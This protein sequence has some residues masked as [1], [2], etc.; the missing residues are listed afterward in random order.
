MKDRAPT[1]YVTGAYLRYLEDPK[2]DLQLSPDERGVR[3]E[4][5]VPVKFS[6]PE[7]C[8]VQDPLGALASPEEPGLQHLGW[9]NR[10]ARAV[11]TPICYVTRHEDVRLDRLG[12]P[13]W[14]H[15]FRRYGDPAILRDA[16]NAPIEVY[17]TE[18]GRAITAFE[19]FGWEDHLQLMAASDVFRP[20]LEKVRDFFETLHT[21]DATL[22]PILQTFPGG[23][24]WPMASGG[25]AK[26]GR[27]TADERAQLYNVVRE[28]LQQES[29]VQGAGA[30]EI[31][32]NRDRL[33]ITV[34]HPKQ[35][36]DLLLRVNIGPDYGK[37]ELYFNTKKMHAA[38]RAWLEQIAKEVNASGGPLL[39]QPQRENSE[40]RFGFDI[41]FPQQERR[42]SKADR[43]AGALR[44]IL[45]VMMRNYAQVG[46]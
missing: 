34:R 39:L 14:T 7:K 29:G 13:D 21:S 46:A 19:T 45:P 20:G 16:P 38:G 35:R 15:P 24:A 8:L 9:L 27:Y 37:K 23:A 41:R 3:F 32:A 33:T 6:L 26:P 5:V 18:H 43:M 12:T 30:M 42:Q 40:R 1:L 22:M 44:A 28:L 2:S 36:D 17:E 25:E 4:H 10:I 31:P 11:L